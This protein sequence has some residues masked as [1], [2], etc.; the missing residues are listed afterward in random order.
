MRLCSRRE[1]CLI[2]ADVDTFGNPNCAG[3]KYLKVTYSCVDS[4][5]LLGTSDR[6]TST[7]EIIHTTS[8]PAWVR[9]L[10]HSVQNNHRFR[11]D[12]K[13]PTEPS[14]SFHLEMQSDEEDNDSSKPTNQKFVNFLSGWVSARKYVENNKQKFILYLAVSLSVGIIAFLT[15]LGVRLFVIRRPRNS[16]KLDITPDT[17][18][19]FFSDSDLEQF[20]PPEDLPP[21]PPVTTTLRRHD[22]DAQ[23]R[24]PIT[25][26]PE[27]N[28]Y[29][30]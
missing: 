7:E 9:G 1:E 25:T 24:A 16:S 18:D 8:F 23:P 12:V 4:K 13:T 15:V 5:L 30:S 10:D 20:D 22:S 6:E 17:E 19:Q 27:L 2:A 28:H 29:F 21:A 3:R 14:N 26:G 11:F